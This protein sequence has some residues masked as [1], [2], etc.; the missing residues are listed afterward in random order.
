MTYKIEAIVEQ[1]LT[2]AV[3]ED[4]SMDVLP[5]ELIASL[6]AHQRHLRELAL[7]L[8]AGGQPEAIVRMAIEQVADSFS[9]ELA[10]SIVALRKAP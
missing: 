2:Q 1:A 5:P 4:L 10:H 8:F 6:E 9:T 7:S 3:R